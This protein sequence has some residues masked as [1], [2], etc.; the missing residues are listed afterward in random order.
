MIVSIMDDSPGCLINESLIG[1][2]Q[3]VTVRAR[4]DAVT[5]FLKS[6]PPKEEKLCDRPMTGRLFPLSA[7]KSRPSPFVSKILI[8][9]SFHINTK[10][11]CSERECSRKKMSSRRSI[12]P[13]EEMCFHRRRQMWKMLLFLFM[14]HF[15]G[16]RVSFTFTL[17]PHSL[18]FNNK[19]CKSSPKQQQ[20]HM[21]DNSLFFN[22]T[23]EISKQALIF[24]YFSALLSQTSSTK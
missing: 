12:N 1:V 16:S 23:H 5:L 3:H 15:F 24:F 19:A 9:C 18:I 2:E 8:L 13:S 6:T 7:D 11:K 20:Q 22:T 10:K 14:C 4:R 21:P 17:A